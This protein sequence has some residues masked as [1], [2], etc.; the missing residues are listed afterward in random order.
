[1]TPEQRHN[2]MS[3]IR[4]KN[5]KPEIRVRKMAFAMG[6]RFRLHDKRLPGTPDIVFPRLKKVIFVHG[7][8]WHS[9]TCQKQR[10]LPQ[11]HPEFW[12]AK[13]EHNKKHDREVLAALWKMG[14]EPLVIWECETK[15]E[16]ILR[17]KL[18]NFLRAPTPAENYS[19][20]SQHAL[21]DLA[22]EDG[23]DGK[24]SSGTDVVH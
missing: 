2:C 24:S 10:K 1:M 8:F 18:E 20:E 12:K 11:T 17:E 23:E 7:C 9:H 22:A 14:W 21:Y 4:S 15:S 5:T 6:F 13:L 3:H 16:D 19:L